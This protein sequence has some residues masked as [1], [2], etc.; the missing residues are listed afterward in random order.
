MSFYLLI[1]HTCLHTQM[2]FPIKMYV[3]LF[4]ITV[5]TIKNDKTIFTFLNIF[6]LIKLLLII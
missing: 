4:T 5:R 3:Y 1:I 2:F 6:I